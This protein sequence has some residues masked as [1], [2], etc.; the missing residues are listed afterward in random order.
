M[1]FFSLDVLKFYMWFEGVFIIMYLMV[2]G[3]GY[4]PERYQ[5]RIYMIFYTLVVSLPFLIVLFGVSSTYL[6]LNFFYLH[7]FSEGVIRNLS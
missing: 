6:T 7:F 2:S 1:R 4:S 5:A 3:W